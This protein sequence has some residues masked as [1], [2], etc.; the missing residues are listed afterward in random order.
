MTTTLPARRTMTVEEF[1]AYAL[2]PENADRRL[3]W[4]DGLIIG[5]DQEMVSS[6]SASNT[7]AMLIT[8]LGM[9]LMQHPIAVLTSSDGGYIVNGARYIPDAAVVR[10]ERMR[11][12]ARVGGFLRLAPDLAIEVISPTDTFSQLRRKIQNYLAAGVIVWV[13]DPDYYEIEIHAAGQPNRVLGLNDTLEG[14]DLL[15]GFSAPV[16]AIFAQL[17]AL[18]ATPPEDAE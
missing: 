18:D 8:L 13:I 14:G 10:V 2:L 3:E 12:A 4:H 5:E 6:F 7:A 17:I 9:Y 16:R 15:P 1:E 11:S